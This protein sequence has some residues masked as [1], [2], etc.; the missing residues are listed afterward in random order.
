MI[1][2]GRDVRRRLKDRVMAVLALACVALALIPLGSI[3]Y[4]VVVRGASVVN[5]E[6]FTQIQPIPSLKP[7]RST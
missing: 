4:T 5:P 3:V 1:R 7:I 2:F 6:F